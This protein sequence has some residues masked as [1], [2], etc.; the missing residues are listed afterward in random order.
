MNAMRVAL[1]LS[2]ATAPVAAQVRTPEQFFGFKIGTDGELARYPKVL[3]YMRYLSTSSNRVQYE[4]LGKTTLGNPYVLVRF[5]SPENLSRL[6]RLIEINRRL[7]DPRGLSE[8][9]AMQLTEEGRAFLFLY[10]TIHSTEVGNGQTILEIAHEL[11]TSDSPKVREILE[12]TVLLMVP[13]QN[14]DGQVLV[15][16]HYYKNRG[17]GRPDRYPDLYHKYAGHDDNRDFFMFNQPESRNVARQLYREW[18]PQIV[19]DQHQSAPFPAR[20]FIPPFE[21]PMNP[22][23]PPLV[24]ISSPFLRLASSS[25]CRFRAWPEGRRMRK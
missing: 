11:A 6:D 13:S 9:E 12:N 7:A 5:S 25:A 16:D 19:Y 14:P 15:I 4:E 22:R 3:E 10:A 23:I 21:D 1:L 8:S 24:M 18:Y 2:L 17:T 20:I